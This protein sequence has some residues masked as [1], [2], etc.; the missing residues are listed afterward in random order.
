MNKYYLKSFGFVTTPSPL[1]PTKNSNILMQ[2]KCINHFGLLPP[3]PTSP[4]GLWKK[5]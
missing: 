3:S 4:I 5:S 2:K 1:F